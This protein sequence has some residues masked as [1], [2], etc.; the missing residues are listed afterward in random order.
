[1]TTP[2]AESD[3]FNATTLDYAIPIGSSK[4]PRSTPGRVRIISSSFLRIPR[5]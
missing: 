4:V 2:V 1:M 5:E 3:K